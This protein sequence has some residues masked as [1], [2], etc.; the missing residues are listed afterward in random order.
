ML[1]FTLQGMFRVTRDGVDCAPRGNKARALLAILALTPGHRKMRV[2]LQDKLWS[3]HGAEQA[4]G[5][6]RQTLTEIRNAFGEMR[7]AVGSDSRSIWLD[8]AHVTFD[9]DAEHVAPKAGDQNPAAELLED[10]IVR[11]VEYQHWARMVQS[12]WEEA[13][14]KHAVPIASSTSPAQASAAPQS[15]VPVRLLFIGEGNTRGDRFFARF[16]A[17]WAL[18]ATAE[19]GFEAALCPDPA[20]GEGHFRLVVSAVGAEGGTGVSVS[21]VT[22]DGR[23]A[24]NQVATIDRRRVDPVVN[25]AL[26]RQVHEG[27]DAMLDA[28]TRNAMGEQLAPAVMSAL[29]ARKLFRLGGANFGDA[30]RLISLA[31]QREQSH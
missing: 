17:S 11:D 2:S 19:N 3:D 30:E 18:Q 13:R 23:T 16:L 28:V 31:M 5:S 9:I 29:G 7:V 21:V 10:I 22:P 8:A 4:A 25:A 14:A 20:R 26:I 12:A 27:V 6:L 1:H 24:W 15:G